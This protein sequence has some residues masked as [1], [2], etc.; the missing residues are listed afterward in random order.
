M[1]IIFYIMLI[2]GLFATG[3]KS[4]KALRAGDS[5][6]AMKWGLFSV[7]IVL[8]WLAI[9]VILRLLDKSVGATVSS[10]QKKTVP[11]DIYNKY[12]A[13]D[14]KIVNIIFSEDVTLTDDF[15]RTKTVKKGDVLRGDI[16]TGSRIGGNLTGLIRPIPDMEYP[17]WG[18][19]E[20]EVWKIQSIKEEE[21][22]LVD[23]RIAE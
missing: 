15:G 21:S 4:I 10:S 17:V 18:F 20:F 23:L 12:M 1:I 8:L 14:G 7:G 6:E 3:K 16:N 11:S 2:I 19:C 13:L 9:A 22:Q 5:K